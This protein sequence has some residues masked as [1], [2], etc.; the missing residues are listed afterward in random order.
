MPCNCVV[1]VID[2]WRTFLEFVEFESRVKKVEILLSK[3]AKIEG[4]FK[5][6][7]CS[8]KVCG[9]RVSWR[10]KLVNMTCTRIHTLHPHTCRIFMAGKCIS[11]FTAVM[12]VFRW[13]NTTRQLAPTSLLLEGQLLFCFTGEWAINGIPLKMAFWHSI[14]KQL[15]GPYSTQKLTKV[16]ILNYENCT[17]R[18]YLSD[19]TNF[20]SFKNILIHSKSF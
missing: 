7:L 13:Q 1:L 9:V 11:Y 17:C 16:F 15:I 14:L 20:R 18:Q 4:E 2:M 8:S 3:N 6:T 19:R 10:Q 5:W 12:L